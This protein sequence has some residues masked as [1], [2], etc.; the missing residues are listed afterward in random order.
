[1]TR[2]DTLARPAI[3]SLRGSRIR[4]VSQSVADTS[5]VLA[6]WFGEPD[7]VTPAFVREAAKRAL[8]AGD[9]YYTSNY[10]IAPLREALARYTSALHQPIDAGRIAV[11]SAGV[12]ALN[13]ASQLLVSPGDRVV[14]VTPVWPNL[15]EIPKILGAEVVEAPLAFVAGPD[16]AAEWA[17]DIEMLLDRLTPQTRMVV[18]NSPN[19]PSGWTMPAWQQRL[20]LDHCRRL[21]IW[22]LSD[23]V[24]ERLYY[25]E[26]RLG[27]A[28]AFLDIADDQDRLLSVN[29]FSKNWLMTGWRLGWLTAPAAIMNDLGKLLEYNTSC[30]PGFV[31]RAGLAAL[32]SGDAVVRDTVARFRAARDRL[33]AGLQT[34]PGVTAN[35][36]PGGMYLFFRVEG[37]DDS[38]SL[39][40]RLVREV[41]LGLAPG[42]A[43]GDAGE[44]AIRWCFASDGERLDEGVR[45]LA[46]FL[47]AA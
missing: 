28:P 43:F 32:D 19:N 8:D 39:C 31:Q 20:V 42:S 34:I 13:L 40:K 36:P 4:E 38:L 44:G 29:S 18:I 9:T 30:A 12:S 5:D 41:K 35:L 3:Q 2:T 45:R 1:M 23:D 15:V 47:R 46:D 37:L 14:V 25:G 10:G 7:A 27:C 22:I 26:S 24:Y 6:F 11:T 16:G 17:L 21:G 33:F